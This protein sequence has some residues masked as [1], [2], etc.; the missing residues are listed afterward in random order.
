[1]SKTKLN[2]LLLLSAGGLLTL[3]IA[4][5]LPGLILAAG[6]PFIL[7]QFQLPSLASG[8]SMGGSEL[9][10][11]LFRGITAVALVLLPFSIIYSLLSA[12]GRRR[13]V[14]NLLIIAALVWIAN[15]L[16]D[17]TDAA[18]QSAQGI[19]TLPD[20]SKLGTPGVSTILPTTLPPE[21]TTGIILVISIVIALFMAG[22]IA[23]IW[24][25]MKRPESVV[26]PIAVEAQKAI[27][28]IRAGH[29]LKT[30]V[31]A[32]YREMSRVLSEERGIKRGISMTPREFEDRLVS[33]GLPQEAI[34]T[35]TRLFERVRYGSVAA[36]SE[37]EKLALACLTDIVTS[38]KTLE[39]EYES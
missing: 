11:W 30:T 4:L 25:H 1:M 26:E 7:P 35:L 5:S 22:A 23:L 34:G 29:D 37:E 20:T 17:R 15:Y 12:E 13:L 10:Y 27:D 28:A 32:C 8:S 18:A 9:V 6:H 3:I 19:P 24:Q 38:C 36:G 21:V 14:I 39:P 16:R 31:V 33:K 2:V